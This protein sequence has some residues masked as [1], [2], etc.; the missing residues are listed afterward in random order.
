M[1]PPA[2]W[3]LERG[4]K[5]MSVRVKTRDFLEAM[6]V[7]NACAKIAEK[8]QHH[9]DFHL[10]KWNR[11]KITTWSHDVGGLTA[12][13]ARLARRINAVLRTNGLAARARSLR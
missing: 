5:K 6:R 10:V 8:I 7:M 13:D 4:G 9:P 3:K 2:G 11:L 1:R 12:R